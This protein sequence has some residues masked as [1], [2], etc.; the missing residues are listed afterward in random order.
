MNITG[1]APYRIHV[2]WDTPKVQLRDI[3][4]DVA[5]GTKSNAYSI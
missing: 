4:L 5:T 3:Q 2:L 1:L